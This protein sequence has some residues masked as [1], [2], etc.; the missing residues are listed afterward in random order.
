[1][2]I[3]KQIDKNMLNKINTFISDLLTVS[4]LTRTRHK[5]IKIASL[6]LVLNL[7]IFF[8]ILIILFFSK[9]FAEDIGVSNQF[10]DIILS[11][12]FFSSFYFF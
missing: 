3:R 2:L 4:K 1:M 9:L 5:K 8:D 6:A 10:I 7:L 11:N 12:N